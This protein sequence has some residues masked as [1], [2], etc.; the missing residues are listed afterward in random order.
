MRSASAIPLAEDSFDVYS[1]V[2]AMALLAKHKGELPR[3]QRVQREAAAVE[4]R[5]NATDQSLTPHAG[6]EI[7]SWSDPIEGE[8]RDDQGICFKNPD[9]NLFMRY[10]LAGA[11]DS[12]IALLVTTGEDRHQSYEHLREVLRRTV[13]RGPDLHT[14][15]QFHYGLVHWFLANG[16]DAKP[17]TRFVVPYLTLVGELLREANEIDAD[18]A[19]ERLCRQYLK[20]A[21]GDPAAAKATSEISVLKK[22]LLGRPLG[23]VLRQPHLLSAWLSSNKNNFEVKDHRVTWLRNPLLVLAETYHLL[24]MDA[25]VDLPA[26]HRIW[27]QDQAILQEGAAFYAAVQQRVGDLS[28][29]ELDA[30]LKAKKPAKGFE[31]AQWEQVREAHLGFQLGMELYSLLPLIGDKVG[32][33]DLHLNDD[34]TITIPERLFDRDHQAKMK[35]VL[36]P[37]PVNKADEIVAVSGGMYYAQEAPGLPR[38]IQEGQHFEI[39]DPLYVVEVMK[40]FNKVYAPFAGTVDKILVDT[41]GTIVSKGQPLFKV[42]PDDMFVEEDPVEVKARIESNTERYLTVVA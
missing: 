40:M 23:R 16:V 2:E 24:H 4:A 19:Y 6:G 35:K 5:L 11:Y 36:V 38:F 39:G 37:P 10:K 9:T 17:T 20:A 13:L 28:W 14:N 42:T 22:T 12:N 27:E 26:A 31:T 30:G 7:M 8:V 33:F 32:F 29:P 41:D 1:L 3:P 15:L 18:Y 25:A 34:L 21:S